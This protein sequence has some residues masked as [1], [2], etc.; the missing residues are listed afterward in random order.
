MY[1]FVFFTFVLSAVYP[2]WPTD[3]ITNSQVIIS[4]LQSRIIVVDLEL[5]E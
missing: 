4:D 3:A 5:P 1:K 2:D